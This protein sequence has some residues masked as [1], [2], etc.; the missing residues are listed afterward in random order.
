MSIFESA[1]FV[2][3]KFQPCL[4]TGTI[5]D[6]AL[7][8]YV[9]G[10]NG[11]WIL[12]GGLAPMTGITG[13]GGTYKSTAFDSL[14]VRVLMRYPLI[15]VLKYDTE[16]NAFTVTRFDRMART[17]E[18]SHRILLTNQSTMDV[19]EFQDNLKK[20]FE[21]RE[22]DKYSYTVE[23]PFLDLDT[24]KPALMWVPLIVY[25]DSF[26]MLRPAAEEQS[27]KKT[28]VEDQ[29]NNTND[30]NDGRMKKALISL[31][32]KWSQRYGI[33]FMMTAQLG[34]VIKM[35]MYET[36]TKQN[37]WFK[38]NDNMKNVGPLFKYLTNTLLQAINPTPILASDKKS[39]EYPNNHNNENSIDINELN[40]RI[41]RCKT[42]LSGGTIPFVMSQ[43]L[44]ILSDLTNYHYLKKNGDFGYN[45]KGYSRYCVL[46]PDV[47]LTRMDIIDTLEN[48]YELCRALEILTQLKWI[49]TYWNIA[50]MDVNI[51]ETAE[52]FVDMVAAQDTLL[53]S[54][55]LNSRG[56]WTY[57]KEDKRPYL[58]TMDI[59]EKIQK[60]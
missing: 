18:V 46:K 58:S 9:I 5:L 24:G 34:N 23:T 43:N 47:K 36:V 27:S 25:I 31:F 49:T 1:G 26:T 10:T 56:Y 42:S 48:D 57:N 59:I 51:P 17:E 22:R 12:N 30:M 8:D 6:I 29:S 20:L 15:E 55:I 37:Q 33:Y 19:D 54:D 32:S 11:E 28:N 14:I 60:R 40:I 35:N 52:K 41:I 21:A 50:N 16:Q 45:V 7:G 4:N 53:I 44:G 3:A 38:Q 2:K 39:A 13:Y